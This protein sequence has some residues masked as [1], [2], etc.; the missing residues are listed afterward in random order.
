MPPNIFRSF[1][2]NVFVIF[3]NR[4]LSSIVGLSSVDRTIELYVA[5]YRTARR[6]GEPIADCLYKSAGNTA[7]S[8]TIVEC[9]IYILRCTC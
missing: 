6:P 5:R 3:N 2:T 1:E 9:S 8:R 7:T 4:Q